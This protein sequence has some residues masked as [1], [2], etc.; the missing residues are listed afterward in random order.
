VTTSRMHVADRGTDANRCQEPGQRWPAPDHAWGP[1]GLDT[2]PGRHP[3]GPRVAIL[4]GR[5]S[6][7]RRPTGPHPAGARAQPRAPGCY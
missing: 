2:P 6:L 4:A 5:G 7:T 3:G 1:G